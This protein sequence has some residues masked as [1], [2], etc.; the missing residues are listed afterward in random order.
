MF[1]SNNK[2]YTKKKKTKV[3]WELSSRV[4]L[5]WSFGPRVAFVVWGHLVV[6]LFSEGSGAFFGQ[7]QHKPKN[8]FC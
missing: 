6:S 8:F 2:T 4:F 1:L 3:G 7:K 5:K